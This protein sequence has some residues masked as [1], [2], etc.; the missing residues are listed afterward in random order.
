MKKFIFKYDPNHSVEGMFNRLEESLQT[1]QKSIQPKNVS[2]AS[3]ITV[4]YEILS[5]PRLELFA[6]LVE[7]QP[8][9]LQELAQFLH[10]DYFEVE[11]DSQLLANLGIIKLKKQ[12]Q[13]TQP[14]ALY[15]RIVIDL[16]VQVSRGRSPETF[17]SA[18]H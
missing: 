10:R 1:G 5:K 3:D 9:N 13:E 8:K 15:E 12:A 11:A 6:C 16:P 18:S 2:I 7:K 4:I 17:P 14:I